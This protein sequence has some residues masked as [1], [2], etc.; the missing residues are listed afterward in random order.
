MVHTLPD[1]TTKYKMVTL[2]GQIDMGEVAAR[3]GSPVTFDRRGQI[4][5]IDDFEA[6][7]L[8][9]TTS[10][11][12]TGNDIS[13]ATNAARNG[14]QSCR[15]TGGSDGLKYALIYRYLPLPVD[16]QIGFEISFCLDTNLDYF[17]VIP[18][19][20]DGTNKH[21]PQ[22]RFDRADAILYVFDHNGVG[23]TIASGVNLQDTVIL[24]HTL[25]FVVDRSTGYYVR[26]ILNDTE[27]DISS[28]QYQVA[29]DASDPYISMQLW[30]M[31]E[32][33]EN[34]VLYLDDFILT[35]NE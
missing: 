12:G 34:G 21:S 9:W 4:V 17:A 27:Y 32:T 15:L 22:I 5:M 20:F 7:S 14:D 13:L 26:C 28:Y 24:F 10:S 23:Q 33:G 29:A 6:A 25:K 35:Q 31:P 30:N 2:F 11:W 1:Y 19:F 3:L 16:S 18:V 8:K